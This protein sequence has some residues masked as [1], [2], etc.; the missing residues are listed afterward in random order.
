MAR[1]WTPEQ[2]ASL[3]PDAA[4]LK[5]AQGLAS[6]RKWT[7][8]GRDERF[9]WGLAQ[10]S[11]KDPYQSQ[12]D[13]EET[14]FKC[15]CPSR[16]FPCKHGLGLL[17]IY[18]SQPAVV[19]S[20]A[21][22]AW[23]DEWAAKRAER[24]AK[25]EAKAQETV[26]APDPEAQAKRREKR[27]ANVARGVE[28]LE[29]WLRDLVR[30]GTAAVQ[31]AGYKFWDEPARRLVDAQAPGLARRLRLL[32]GLAGSAAGEAQLLTGLGRL[33]LLLAA[34]RRR[35]VLAPEWQA[36]IDSQLGWTVEQDE[37]RGRDGVR[38]VWFAAAQTSSEEAG[39][40]TRS[41]YLFSGD[42]RSAQVLEFSH[43][44]QAAA[45][46]LAVGRSFE[47]E[48]VYFPGVEPVRALL[49]A[50]P[51]DAPRRPLQFLETCAELQAA[52]AARLAVSPWREEFAALVRLT[53]AN[54]GERWWL[55][56]SAGEALPIAADF[57]AGWELLA[58]SGGRELE[59]CGV[60]DGFAFR[61]L[62]VID[63]AGATPLG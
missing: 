6:P 49:M 35:E 55:Q 30:Q 42:G 18:A 46:A 14:A 58:C 11:G 60:W 28:Y 48:L 61:P 19:P 57:K 22:P 37:M 54:D 8:L 43:A 34:A 51:A 21:R 38:A 41:T 39:V 23:V 12:I 5:A 9:V 31:G 20:V 63:E 4:S 25:A 29:G 2:A 52:H 26:P 47:G 7:L 53:P 24:A 13:L 50:P 10:G 45:A 17:L 16:K 32:G 33:H 3:A 36:E 56:D 40:V 27:A 62:S 1:S 15:S 59:M 44:S